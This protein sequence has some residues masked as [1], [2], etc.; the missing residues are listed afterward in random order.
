MMYWPARAVTW[1]EDAPA[2]LST[3]VVSAAKY[4]QYPWP[5]V[6][7]ADPALV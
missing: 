4:I 2:A 5:P 6:T 1:Y 7:G 3:T